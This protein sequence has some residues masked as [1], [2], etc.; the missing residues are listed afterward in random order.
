MRFIATGGSLRLGALGIQVTGDR[1]VDV[2]YLVSCICFSSYTKPFA[3]PFL[4]EQGY[5]IAECCHRQPLLAI[6]M[7]CTQLILLLSTL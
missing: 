4:L 1:S 2:P 3:V 7:R 5:N 6:M